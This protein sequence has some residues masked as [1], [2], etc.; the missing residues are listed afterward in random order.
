MI[1]PST[2]Y[3]FLRVFLTTMFTLGL[4]SS[5]IEFKYDYK[6]VLFI[7][8]VYM[9]YVG[10]SSWFII[11]AFGFYAL[12]KI[13]IFTISIPAVIVVYVIAKDNA[14]QAVFNYMTQINL[15]LWITATITLIGYAIQIHPIMELAIRCVVYSILIYLEFHF[16]R[17]PFQKVAKTFDGNWLLLA[18]VPVLFTAIFI[19]MGTLPNHYS[20]DL[21]RIVYLYAV[22]VV[23]IFVYIIIFQV[24]LRLYNMKDTLYAQQLLNTQVN[25]LSLQLETI[26]DVEQQTRIYRHDMKH[27]F[28]TLT[29]LMK[30]ND[31]DAALEYV[32]AITLQLE[33][34]SVEYYC[35]NRTINAMLSFYL[36]RAKAKGI[37]VATKLDIPIHLPIDVVETSAV[38]ANMIENAINACDE[39][40]EGKKKS[41][42]LQCISKPQFIIEVTNTFYG[43]IWFDDEGFPIR[44]STKHGVGSRSIAAFIKKYDAI[45]DYSFIDNCFKL[46]ILINL[47]RNES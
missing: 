46:R 1:E 4:M 45:H 23:M 19:L 26:E 24:I 34:T 8:G 28:R 35:E 13:F 12:A 5:L 25:A 43:K 29:S 41:I 14:M 37:E 40:S 47:P 21:W 39:I 3:A 7:F 17:I 36:K 32:G 31:I 18:M 6:K 16:L 27:Y 22:F 15:S 38:L 20:H 42:T 9:A 2:L 33:S 11:F 44:E 30:N 10:L